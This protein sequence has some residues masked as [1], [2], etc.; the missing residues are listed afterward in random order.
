MTKLSVNVNKVALLRNTRA[1]GIPSVTRAAELAIAGGAYGITVHPRP[2]ARHITEQ[3]VDDLSALLEAHPNIEFNI[4]G[5]PF[6]NLMPIVRRVRPDQCTLVPD[7]PGQ[8]TSDHGWDVAASA[9]RLGP[10]IRELKDLGCRVSLFMD[11]VSDQIARIPA[12]GADRIELYTE[13]YAAAYAQGAAALAQVVP[14]FAAAARQATVLGLGVNAGHDLNLQNLTYFC[15][16]VPSV[17]EV[18]IGHALIAD[19][20]EMGLTATVRAYIRALETV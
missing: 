18:S 9:D 3:D 19:A 8:F 20:L 7:D 15:R 10:V 2:D 17:L 6:H 5:N 12:L 13:P 4:E 16:N 11:P 14:L 1:L